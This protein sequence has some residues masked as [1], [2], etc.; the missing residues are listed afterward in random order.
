MNLA[1]RRL[2]TSGSKMRQ[3]DLKPEVQYD[4]KLKAQDKL[5]QAINKLYGLF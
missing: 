5:I 4:L 1:K 2:R 3:R